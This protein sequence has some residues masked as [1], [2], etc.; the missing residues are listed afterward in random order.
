[1]EVIANIVEEVIQD[2]GI[3][4]CYVDRNSLKHNKVMIVHYPPS[5]TLVET[6]ICYKVDGTQLIDGEDIAIDL[7][8]PHSVGFLKA[9]IGLAYFVH[10]ED[11]D[12]AGLIKLPFAIAA[13]IWRCRKT[14]V[15]DVR[16]EMKSKWRK[17][18]N[19]RLSG[20]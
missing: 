16:E 17:R 1:M 15:F 4:D 8:H 13:F 5:D 20:S 10:T 11:C 7:A 3:P 19:R 6:V 9:D 18:L 14:I 12:A 2:L